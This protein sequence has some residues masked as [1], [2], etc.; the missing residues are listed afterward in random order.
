[1]FFGY[2]LKYVSYTRDA[3]VTGKYFS[4]HGSMVYAIEFKPALCDGSIE[5]IS[6]TA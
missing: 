4:D 2:V 6:N 1:M 3:V 5:D